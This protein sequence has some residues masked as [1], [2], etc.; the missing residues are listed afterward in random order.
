MVPSEGS[1]CLLAVS[2]RVLLCS[3]AAPAV[4]HVPNKGVQ[5]LIGPETDRR[6]RMELHLLPGHATWARR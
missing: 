5:V 3:D 6:V 2:W 1:K 4:V